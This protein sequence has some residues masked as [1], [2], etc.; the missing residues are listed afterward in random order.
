MPG[1]ILGYE[2]PQSALSAFVGFFSA[3]FWPAA[4][5]ARC[6]IGGPKRRIQPERYA[7]LGFEL[8]DK[9]KNECII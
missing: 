5:L 6:F 8:I 9:M 3:T 1:G 4:T 7:K 2:K